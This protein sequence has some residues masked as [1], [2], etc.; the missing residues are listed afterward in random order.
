M[1]LTSEEVAAQTT[2]DK[3]FLNGEMY[4]MIVTSIGATAEDAKGHAMLPF[5]KDVVIQALQNNRMKAV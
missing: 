2:T 4:T 3:H 5:G 1:G